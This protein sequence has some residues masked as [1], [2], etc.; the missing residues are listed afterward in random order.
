MPVQTSLQII[1]VKSCLFLVGFA[2]GRKVGAS[3]GASFHQ[4]GSPGPVAFP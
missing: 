2:L 1:L 4:E 3:A